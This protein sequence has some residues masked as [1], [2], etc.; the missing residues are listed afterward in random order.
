[1]LFGLVGS[2]VPSQHTTASTPAASAVRIIVPA[3]PGSRTSTQTRSVEQSRTSSRT[4]GTK[5]TT[6][7]SGCGV[8][9]SAIR[10]MT[11]G[12]RSNTRAPRVNTRSTTSATAAL[13]RPSGARYTDST[14]APA[15]LAQELADPSDPL[16]GEGE[17]V[18]GQEPASAL[19]WAPASAS[20]ATVT[21]D[22]KASGSVTARSA[23]TLRSTSTSARW[24][25]AM[26]RL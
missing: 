8:T 2:T 26:N 17:P 16:V 13:D 12:A 24:R 25:P 9:V 1:M 14:G 20:L 5:P 7:R 15:A 22:A 11:P 18:L 23:S 10:S 19:E 3:L 4:A 21:S 6:A